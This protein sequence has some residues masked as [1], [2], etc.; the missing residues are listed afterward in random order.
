MQRLL[1]KCCDSLVSFVE[2]KNRL[3]DH[4][5]E[6]KP[7]FALRKFSEI[8][9]PPLNTKHLPSP[10]SATG[11]FLT[12]LPS[13][14]ILQSETKQSSTYQRHHRQPSPFFHF[15]VVNPCQPTPILQHGR[16][17]L[18]KLQVRILST[19]CHLFPRIINQLVIG[20]AKRVTCTIAGY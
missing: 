11:S 19:P 2:K 3:K 18:I 5:R 20:H 14:H 8:K 15:P 10:A 7:T 13:S 16:R 17:A 1:M 12:R 4:G 9:Q 6:N